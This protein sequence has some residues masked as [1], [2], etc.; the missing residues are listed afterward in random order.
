MPSDLPFVKMQLG[1]KLIPDFLWVFWFFVQ[2]R[3]LP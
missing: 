2:S 1:V 3:K